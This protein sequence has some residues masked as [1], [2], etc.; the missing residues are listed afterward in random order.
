MPEE[1]ASFLVFAKNTSLALLGMTTRELPPEPCQGAAAYLV[2]LV[3]FYI[4]LTYSISLCSKKASVRENG[5][6]TNP[7]MR[8]GPLQPGCALEPCVDVG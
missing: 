5:W 7:Q 4:K 1:S 3:S 6:C 2:L 8:L